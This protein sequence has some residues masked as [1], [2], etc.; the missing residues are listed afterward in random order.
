MLV[1]QSRSIRL[2]IEGEGL[3][4]KAAMRSLQGKKGD[5]LKGLPPT[6]LA[7]SAAGRP[8]AT[9]PPAPVRPHA[10]VR[11]G[12]CDAQLARCIPLQ[13]RPGCGVAWSVGFA[14]S[15]G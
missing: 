1:Q 13:I 11:D 14:Q 10:C 9:P 6:Q 7:S 3:A 4:S 8:T 5:I 12:L 15:R 2:K